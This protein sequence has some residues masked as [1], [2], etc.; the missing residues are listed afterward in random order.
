M[1]QYWSV[2]WGL[3]TPALHHRFHLYIT[4][5]Q[6][7]LFKKMKIE[8]GNFCKDF[9]FSRKDCGIV[10]PN[11]TKF[12]DSPTSWHT[13][14]LHTVKSLSPSLYRW[15]K[16]ITDLGL[17]MKSAGTWIRDPSGKSEQHCMWPGLA[18]QFDCGMSLSLLD[19]NK[20]HNDPSILPKSGSTLISE[21][22]RSG[23]QN[24]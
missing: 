12:L 15:C 4:W 17:A 8:I 14:E 13:R 23:F 10:G 18:A 2:A 9:F 21:Q 22:I 6:I 3:V 11:P 20:N 16:I 5:K 7:I 24:F 1:D 19:N